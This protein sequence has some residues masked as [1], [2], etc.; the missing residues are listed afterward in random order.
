MKNN[1]SNAYREVSVQTGVLNAS[2][3]QLVLM[4]FDGFL[5]SVSRARGAI[6]AQNIELKCQSII[7][8]VRII[9]EGL[10]TNLNLQQ[11]GALAADLDALYGYIM[12][13]LTY[14][15]IHNHIA[16]LEECSRL[17]EP[18]RNAW[19]AIGSSQALSAS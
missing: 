9:D 12:M 19:I 13:R 16:A 7:R 3:H 15:N 10:R 14:A 11:G 1:F 8:A 2:P 5:E 6:A 4:L 17:I 18:I